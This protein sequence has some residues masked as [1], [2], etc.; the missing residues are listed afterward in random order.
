L[1]GLAAYTV[2]AGDAPRG[3]LMELHSCELFAGGCVVSSEAP[4][5]GRYM[6]R[7]WDF[8]GGRFNETDL[9]GLKLAVLQTS[10]DNLALKDSKSGDAVVYLPQSA[11]QPQRDALLAWLR[12][13]QKDFQPA[14]LHTRIVPLQCAKTAGGYALSA[15]EFIHVQ[16]ASTSCDSTACG[17]ALWY[18]PRTA[19]TL[20][21]VALN[22]ASN[23]TEPLLKLT[24]IDAGKR[25]VFLARFGETESAKDVYVTMGE[26]C[27]SAK[28]L[29]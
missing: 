11:T 8:T 18:E 13:S 29:F 12:S 25:S 4:Q 9:K 21:T 23:V 27:G 26:L 28:S 17:E 14:R 7:V 2:R 24:W 20:F 1:F 19:T 10:A 15:G 22:N 3:S 16:S 6:L 5:G